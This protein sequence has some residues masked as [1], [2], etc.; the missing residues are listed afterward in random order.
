MVMLRT[1][2]RKR[3]AWLRRDAA[4]RPL[5]QQHRSV[6]DE[7]QPIL[8]SGPRR[9]DTCLDDPSADGASVAVPAV[10]ADAAS[11]RTDLLEEES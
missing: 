9:A 2:L 8:F 7:Q 10:D 5:A 4:S 11:D 3:Q 1:R 6:W